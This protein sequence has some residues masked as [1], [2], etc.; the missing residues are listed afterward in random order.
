MPFFDEHEIKEGEAPAQQ[1]EIGDRVK[2][3]HKIPGR[4][5]GWYYHDYMIFWKLDNP[6]SPPLNH[7]VEKLAVFQPDWK[8]GKC[9]WGAWSEL[10]KNFGEPIE[11]TERGVKVNS[12]SLVLIH[13]SN[14][15]KIE[16]EE[17]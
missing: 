13:P 8:L 1:F 10:E 3:D 17:E 15:E 2:L 9:F 16:E 12:F 4:I 14:L 5:A 7:E 11:L 6:D